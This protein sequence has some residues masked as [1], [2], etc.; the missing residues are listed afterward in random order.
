MHIIIKW[1]EKGFALKL[2]RAFLVAAIWACQAGSLTPPPG[3]VDSFSAS[4]H[5]P[6]TTLSH[7]IS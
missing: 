2:N 5:D 7:H 3:A 1:G 4:P 6:G